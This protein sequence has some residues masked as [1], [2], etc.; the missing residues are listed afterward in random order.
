[1]R[2]PRWR[3]RLSRLLRAL[4]EAVDPAPEGFDLDAAP[5]FW[6]DRVREAGAAPGGLRRVGTRVFGREE[7][8]ETRAGVAEQPPRE[9]HMAPRHEVR[10]E[11]HRPEAEQPP[12]QPAPPT[13][14]RSH[15]RR[16]PLVRPR[17][18][19]RSGLR[20]EPPSHPGQLA[21]E[22]APDRTAPR[23]GS[24]RPPGWRDATPTSVPTPPADAVPVVRPLP[25]TPAPLPHAPAATPPPSAAQR[26]VATPHPPVTTREQPPTTPPAPVPL[27][28]A[29]TPDPTPPPPPPPAPPA[30][31]GVGQWPDLPPR[32]PPAP[33]VLPPLESSL[34]RLT[35]LATEQ[36]AT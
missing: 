5:S 3:S 28:R 9:H 29:G 22:Q 26:P 27:V 10:P 33:A 34:R 23:T 20:R 12:E 6:A 14:L 18:I 15:Q 24:Q 31:A 2:R 4:A 8:D 25:S 30:P 36:A 16:T 11:Q 21:D 13:A 17:P 19:R 35:R 1:M 32:E 7:P